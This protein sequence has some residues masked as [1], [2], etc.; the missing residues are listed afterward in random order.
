MGVAMNRSAMPWRSSLLALVMMAVV[1]LAT[2]VAGRADAAPRRAAA[3]ASGWSLQTV[4]SATLASGS[5]TAISC[6]GPRACMTVGYYSDSTGA[7][8]PLAQAWNGRTWS[9][10]P[11]PNH[12]SSSATTLSAVSCPSAG[13]CVAAGTWTSVAGQ[14]YP[15]AERWQ[16][17]HWS[18]LAMPD[19]VTATTTVLTGVACASATAC[20]AVGYFDNPYF[21]Q[22]LAEAWNGHRWSVQRTQNVP[23]PTSTV[24][25]Q[26][27]AIW[28]LSA[29]DCTA[30]GDY[31]GSLTQ[32]TLAETWN[33]TTWSIKA[34]PNVRGEPGNA[35]N[36][37]SC[38]SARQC[39]AVGEYTTS[40]GNT[41]TLAQ[42]WNGRA[43]S[44]EKTPAPAGAQNSYLAGAVCPSATV[45]LAVGAAA[46]NTSRTLAEQW[47]GRTWSIEKAPPPAGVA[48]SELSGIWCPSAKACVAVGDD[49]AGIVTKTLAQTWTGSAWSVTP[50]PDRMEPQASDLTGVSCPAPDH[51]VAVGYYTNASGS[52]PL[53]ELW[54][55]KNW[56][57]APA[58]SPAGTQTASLTAV[59][60]VAANNCVAVG[61][62][63]NGS[64]TV[65]L[66]EA[67]NGAHWSIVPTPNVTGAQASVL[68]AV[69]CPAAGHCVAVGYYA[70]SAVT[71]T[72]AQT[73][74]GQVW[75]IGRT[76]NAAGSAFTTL[77]GVSCPAVNRCVAVGGYT[78]APS[79][80]AIAQTWNGSAWAMK[81]L[82]S[83]AGAEGTFP[84]DV[85][86]RSATD[87][88]AVGDYY[89][90]TDNVP[91][92]EALTGPA[93]SV[94][95][96]PAPAGALYS[97]L[98][99]VSC[100]AAGDCVAV[101]FST[102]S[103]S[104]TTSTTLAAAWN[105]HGWQKQ[106]TPNPSGAQQSYLFGESCP[107][108][109][110]CTAIGYYD[111]SPAALTAPFAARY[112][113]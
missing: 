101:G 14:S 102:S 99:A 5:L 6:G 51:C 46:G 15:L 90:G 105:G 25:G 41:G 3:A 43:W 36:A 64:D 96:T 22:T 89:N 21:I 75:S 91:L 57:I 93:W 39:L 63:L 86:C 104:A 2:L 109:G 61:S 4:P 100:P 31:Q 107:L 76:P 82:P 68:S 45:C 85:S 66:A 78:T 28:C 33:G 26:L 29:R 16:G 24:W 77:T 30:V 58:P 32:S 62:S 69:S 94:Q 71:G 113:G 70:A 59:S 56:S 111:K 53:A 19:P 48:E 12:G 17:G 72:L 97:T 87:C 7:Q 73:W 52:S 50:T 1:L 79:P 84:L 9:V 42:A 54:N 83:P 98:D 88:A 47:N 38:R 49:S 34:T 8:V 44:I 20:V 108:P 40:T 67:W 106:P 103:G 11:T 92:A 95:A 81:A 112:Q 10:V 65:T 60:C 37:V 74:N 35:L 27:N 110:S 55:G 18:I 23:N 13:F 80:L